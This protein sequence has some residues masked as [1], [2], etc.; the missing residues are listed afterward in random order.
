[1]AIE[2]RQLKEQVQLFQMKINA[3]TEDID[4]I[5]NFERKL[6]IITGFDSQDKTVPI[7]ELDKTEDRQKQFNAKNS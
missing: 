1:M 3:V 4:R 2:N 7:A 5:Q 6:S